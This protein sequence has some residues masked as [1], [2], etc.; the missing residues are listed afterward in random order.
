MSPWE[1][2]D[3]IGRSFV[4]E[5]V[6]SHAKMAQ[7]QLSRRFPAAVAAATL[8]LPPVQ[9]VTE[10]H[11]RAGAVPAE[12]SAAVEGRQPVRKPGGGKE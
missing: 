6:K 9:L 1:N 7:N 5:P 8:A 12:M 11:G 3:R 10:A 4:Y 2:A